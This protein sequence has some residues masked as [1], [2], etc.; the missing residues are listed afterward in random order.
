MYAPRISAIAASYIFWCITFLL[1]FRSKCFLIPF[2]SCLWPT[3]YLKVCF[4]MYG[5]LEYSKKI[6]K[7]IASLV[8]LW[9]E[10]VAFMILVPWCLLW[11]VLRCHTQFVV[12]NVTYAPEKDAVPSVVRCS[13]ILVIFFSNLLSLL[14]FIGLIYPLLRSILQLSFW[15]K[16]CKFFFEILS[17][18][19]LYVFIYLKFV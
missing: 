6:L 10:Y 5:S 19:T 7:C 8:T 11:L 2:L 12:A 17:I 15:F 14:I 3:S 16:I 4:K 13:S 18:L 1:S 9:I